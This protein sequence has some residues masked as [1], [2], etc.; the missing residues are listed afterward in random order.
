MIHLRE[1]R[2]LHVVETGKPFLKVSHPETILSVQCRKEIT[3]GQDHTTPPQPTTK[4]GE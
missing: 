1:I 3:L 4:N 2:A